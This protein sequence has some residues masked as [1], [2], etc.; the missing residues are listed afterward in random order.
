MEELAAG[1][2]AGQQRVGGI[3]GPQDRRTVAQRGRTTGELQA[4]VHCAKSRWKVTVVS[5][6]VIC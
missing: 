5:F 1:A 6:V 3:N 2:A 4:C